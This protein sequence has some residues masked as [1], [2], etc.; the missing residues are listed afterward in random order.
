LPGQQRKGREASPYGQK[1]GAHLSFCELDFSFHTAFIFLPA[2]VLV[3]LT[4][5]F[6]IYCST[7]HFLHQ[8]FK[9]IFLRSYCWDTTS[10]AI[11]FQFFFPP[12]ARFKQSS[13][14]LGNALSP[15]FLL[16]LLLK[17]HHRSIP[18]GKNTIPSALYY[19]IAKW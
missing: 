17:W 4:A 15:A 12:T 19:V 11:L 7:L 5:I 9:L 13:C 18:N 2:F 3:F 1:L 16:I 14:T 10:I 8:H 6:S